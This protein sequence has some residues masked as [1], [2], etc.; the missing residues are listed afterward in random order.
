[1]FISPIYLFLVQYTKLIYLQNK[2]L[3]RTKKQT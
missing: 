2:I 3:T 1:M